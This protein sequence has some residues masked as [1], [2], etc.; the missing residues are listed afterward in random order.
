MT[1]QD[2]APRRER[3]QAVPLPPLLSRAEIERVARFKRVYE[4]ATRFRIDC[5][6]E[7]E[8]LMNRLDFVRWRFRRELASGAAVLDG[9]C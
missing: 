7:A 4:T 3:G 8:V 6:Q 5:L 9:G 1:Q 2:Q